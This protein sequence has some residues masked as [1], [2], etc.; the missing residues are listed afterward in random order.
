MIHYQ[1][2]DLGQLEMDILKIVNK[3]GIGGR[4]G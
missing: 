3:G 4:I 2:F 1:E